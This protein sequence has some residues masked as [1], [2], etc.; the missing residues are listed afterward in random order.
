MT[1]DA[2]SREAR[3]IELELRVAELERP[4]QCDLFTHRDDG[5]QECREHGYSIPERDWI[6]QMRAI[7][8]TSFE[9]KL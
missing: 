5:R 1:Y 7:H 9:R 6:A 4:R 8:C 3:I 2:R